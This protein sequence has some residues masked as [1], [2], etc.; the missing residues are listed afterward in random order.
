MLEKEAM[1]ISGMDHDSHGND[2]GLPLE[3]RV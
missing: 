1:R 3:N 2:A